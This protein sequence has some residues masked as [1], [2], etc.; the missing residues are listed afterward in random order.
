MGSCSGPTT[1]LTSSSRDPGSMRS[2]YVPPQKQ[3]QLVCETGLT[4]FKNII[5]L[6]NLLIVFQVIDLFSI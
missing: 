3:A 5:D 2:K 4:L 1:S 6:F